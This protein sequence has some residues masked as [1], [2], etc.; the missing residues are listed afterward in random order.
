MTISQS[1]FNIIVVILLSAFFLGAYLLESIGI[2]YVSEG[3]NPLVKIHLYSYLILGVVFVSLLKFGIQNYLHSLGQY[4]ITWLVAICCVLFVIA[5]GLYKQGLSGM[6]YIVDLVFTPL[7]L[8]P[9]LFA[10]TSAQKD[11]IIKILAYLLL[12]NACIAILEFFSGHSIMQVEFSSFSHFRSP[13]FL[14]HPLNNALVTVSL[15]LLLMNKIRIPS[16]VYFFIVL[17]ALFAFGGRG[18]TAVFLTAFA[19]L[20]L[21]A[22]LKFLTCGVQLPKLS[23]AIYQAGFFIAI[24]AVAYTLIMT[25]IGDRILSKLYV[26][27]S[28]QARF[29][30][31][32]L[33]D[34]LSLYEWFFGAGDSIKNN[35]KFFIGI[36]TIE[37]YLIG[38]VVSFGLLGAIPLFTS[39]FLL[40]AR[41]AL[42]LDLR[43]RLVIFSFF[44]TSITN[45]ALSAK[46]IVILF[47]LMALICTLRQKNETL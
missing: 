43:A 13:A 5:F 6:A 38:W 40:P 11:I 21:P 25:P 3:G 39:V 19:V 17:I 18:S 45:N 20:S 32:I 35:I 12:F 24:V 22:A 9:L 8:V 37:N 33:L 42:D 26:D 23:F 16:I 2:K 41:L 15:T 29:D 10:L 4:K 14:S 46:S 34:Q 47:I 7:L 27:G 36:G 30:V 44:F 28:A 1:A 31:F